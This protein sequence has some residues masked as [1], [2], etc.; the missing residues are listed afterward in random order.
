[1]KENNSVLYGALGLCGAFNLFIANE[2]YY[3]HVSHCFDKTLNKS[4]LR[5]EWLILTH[6]SGITMDKSQW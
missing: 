6:G 4:N 1:M 5:K 3:S 2:L